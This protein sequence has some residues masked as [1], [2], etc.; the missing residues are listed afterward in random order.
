LQGR[1]GE[2]SPVVFMTGGPDVGSA[3]F[4]SLSMLLTLEAGAARQLIWAEAALPAIA[5]SF[6]L[7]RQTTAM[8]WEALAARIELQDAGSRVDIFSGDHALDSAIAVSQNEAHR[9]LQS[10]KHNLAHNSFTTTRLPDQGW[11][12]RGNGSDYPPAW[13]GQTALDAYALASALLPGDGDTLKGI[14]RNFIS[15]QQ[16]DGR[17]DFKPGLAGQRTSLRTQ[18]ILGTLAWQIYTESDLD[19]P[20]L[21][22][23]Y[24]P[25]LRSLREW[26]HPESSLRPTWEHA[27]QSGFEDNPLFD[28]WKPDGQ[29]IDPQAIVNPALLAMLYRECASL[30]EM[31]K[32]I[33]QTEDLEWIEARADELKTA[34]EACWDEESGSYRYVEQGLPFTAGGEI[35]YSGGAEARLDLDKDFDPPRHLCLQASLNSA[36][37]RP[38]AVMIVGADAQGPFIETI[39]PRSMRWLDQ[40]VCLTSQRVFS[41]IECVEIRGIEASDQLKIAT[42]D[43]R[44]QD[45]TLLLPLWAA[46]PTQERATAMAENL[47]SVDGRYAT[48]HG[49]SLWPTDAPSPQEPLLTGV[50]PFWNALIAEGLLR[51]GF[52]ELSKQLL[53][54]LAD[55]MSSSLAEQGAFSRCTLPGKPSS[56]EENPV[57]ALF[58]VRLFLKLL[59]LEINTPNRIL[60]RGNSPF[61]S[62]VTVKYRGMKMIRQVAQT[63]I[64]L[65]DGQTVTVD[66]PGPN[67]VATTLNQE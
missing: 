63:Q 42:I 47:I 56:G 54:E 52:T 2:L 10:A 58:P 32:T 7:A 24:P 45:L 18:P 38:L 11:S 41:H 44:Q 61:E 49:L 43:A 12:Q 28:L 31:A 40:R 3:S 51:Y 67:L 64:A 46:I 20:F 6:D 22:E 55:S 53:L 21:R 35:L 50:Y 16:P 33:G 26:L 62:A 23:V 34:V 65:P 25:L 39:T 13:S 14:L 15:S 30:G 19:L 36:V 29:G 1:S 60:I 59:G 37:T 5:D 57:S 48:E 4:P 8:P 17:I 27:L 66:G 9:L